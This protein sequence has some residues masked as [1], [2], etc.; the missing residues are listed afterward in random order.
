MPRF[1][2]EDI[3]AWGEKGTGNGDRAKKSRA[4]RG[5]LA[6]TAPGHATHAFCHLA[7]CSTT[8]RSKD[9]IFRSPRSDNLKPFIT[10]TK[11]LPGNGNGFRKD[12]GKSVNDR[13]AI[14]SHEDKLVHT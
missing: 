1:V 4:G 12:L 14:N 2:N 7:V 3:Q 13:G 8:D 5:A 6:S 10:P 9:P 11:V